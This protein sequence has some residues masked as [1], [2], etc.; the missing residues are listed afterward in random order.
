[1]EGINALLMEQGLAQG[2]VD[3]INKVPQL[4]MITGNV[5][6]KGLTDIKKL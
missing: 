2:Q 1:M 3:S 6:F 5:C 4:Q